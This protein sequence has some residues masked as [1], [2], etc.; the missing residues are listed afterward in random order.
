MQSFDAESAAGVG[1]TTSQG[2]SCLLSVFDFRL[3]PIYHMQHVLDFGSNYCKR[4][5]RLNEIEPKSSHNM[6]MM[7]TMH[8]FLR[9]LS[10][11]ENHCAGLGKGGEKKEGENLSVTLSAPLRVLIPNIGAKVKSNFGW[12]QWQQLLP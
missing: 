4:G 6:W 12:G 9:S 10:R 7:C 3:I 11:V 1:A 2:E 5:S 8:L